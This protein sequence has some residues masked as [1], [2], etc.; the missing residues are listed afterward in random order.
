[1]R[2]LLT[3]ILLGSALSLGGCATTEA[4]AQKAESPKQFI[5]CS[6]CGA[7][8]TSNVGIIEHIKEHPDHKA[9]EPLVECTTCGMQF[10]SMKEATDHVT[11][12]PGHKVAP[13]EGQFI[14]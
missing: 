12:H 9:V 4:P 11:V 2:K 5:K 8:F 10:T 14:K 7:E 3:I 6:T 13:I 1:M